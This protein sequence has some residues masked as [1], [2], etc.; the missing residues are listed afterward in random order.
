MIGFLAS[1]LAEKDLFGPNSE[2]SL[3]DLYNLLSND[4]GGSMLPITK[5]LA[6][7]LSEQE[8][9]NQVTYTILS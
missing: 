8:A 3:N 9:F 5:E 7:E 1:S 6:D 4:I 2:D